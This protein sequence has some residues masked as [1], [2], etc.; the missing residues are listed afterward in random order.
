MRKK[1][2][3]IWGRDSRQREVSA[4]VLRSEDVW[5]VEETG[6]DQCG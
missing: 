2:C 1:S 4:N 5:H 3:D 6:S